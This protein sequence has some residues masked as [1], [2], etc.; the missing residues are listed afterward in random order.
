AAD[1]HTLITLILTIK[2]ENGVPLGGLSDNL[3]LSVK[4]ENGKARKSEFLTL[5]PLKESTRK[6][7]YTATLKGGRAGKYILTPEYNGSPVGN[8]I[9]RVTLTAGQAEQAASSVALDKTE[10]VR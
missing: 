2:N 8:M 5:T 7:K 1:N 6:G 10:Y 9:A 3:T 4:T